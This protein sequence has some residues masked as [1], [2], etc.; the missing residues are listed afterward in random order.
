MDDKLSKYNTSL[1]KQSGALDLVIVLDRSW[2]MEGT[3]TGI[4]QGYRQM[5]SYLKETGK[6]VTVST[7]LFAR[8]GRIAVEGERVGKIGGLNYTVDDGNSFTES[9]TA[10]RDA[11][12]GAIEYENQRKDDPNNPFPNADVLYLIITDGYDNASKLNI[13]QTQEKVRAEREKSVEGKGRREFAVIHEFGLESYRFKQPIEAQD[14]HAQI[15]L[16]G[17]S[18]LRALFQTVDL[19]ASDMMSNGEITEQW[20]EESN[21]LLIGEL[22]LEELKERGM[23]AQDALSKCENAY[24]KLDRLARDGFTSEFVDLFKKYNEYL[25]K[26]RL[27]SGYPQVDELFLSYSAKQ[28]RCQA[29][30]LN[31]AMESTIS[32]GGVICAETLEKLSAIAKVHDTGAVEFFGVVKTYIDTIEK[33][34]RVP[35]IHASLTDE[36]TINQE[37]VGRISTTFGSPS[38]RLAPTIETAFTLRTELL[39]KAL[40]T[41]SPEMF[42]KLGE[43]IQPDIISHLNDFTAYRDFCKEFGTMQK[44]MPKPPK[45]KGD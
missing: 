3:Q 5:L 38:I 33:M 10:M 19:A 23:D 45:L 1:V 25:G 41:K 11:I 32:R 14:T 42:Y 37:L 36:K 16:R 43:F 30:V 27:G 4:T 40:K 26:M 8:K 31:K 20:T 24:M 17:D 29:E 12:N 35:T 34:K 44:F 21:K 6:N 7:L 39:K 15:F 13:E 2:S 18:G 28:R 22:T 9:G